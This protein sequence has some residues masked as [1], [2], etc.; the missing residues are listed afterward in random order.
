[1]LGL[2]RVCR[3]GLLGINEEAGAGG[4][5]PAQLTHEN[6]TIETGNTN[7]RSPNRQ[8]FN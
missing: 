2:G 3:E 4:S 5:A 1:M 6:S 8:Y 7:V